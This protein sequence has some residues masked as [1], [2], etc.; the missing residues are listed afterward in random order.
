MARAARQRPK[1]LGLKLR[2]IR[3]KLELTQEELIE[4]LQD[5]GV[6]GLAQGSI[7]AYESDG[8]EPSLIFLLSIARLVNISVDILI[9]DK[10]DLPE[11]LTARLKSDK[12]RHKQS[13]QGRTRRSARNPND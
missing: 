11:R 10:L 13:A 3:R 1:R 6:K 5:L 7:S 8:R 2:L 9:D 12:V 4:R